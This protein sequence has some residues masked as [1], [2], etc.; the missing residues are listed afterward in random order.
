MESARA[1]NASEVTGS[2][3]DLRTGGEVGLKQALKKWGV[4]G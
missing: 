4:F 3:N 2:G 1:Q